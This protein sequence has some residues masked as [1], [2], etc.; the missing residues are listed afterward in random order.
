[1]EA[2]V[3]AVVFPS[4][5]VG[6]DLEISKEMS[7]GKLKLL[8]GSIESMPFPNNYFKF[9]HCYHVLEHVKRPQQA[10]MEFKRI[11]S[12]DGLIFIGFPIRLRIAPM[13]LKSHQSLNIAK[14]IK[15][16]LRDYRQKVSGKFKNE[17]G[18][19]AG[20]AESEFINIAREYFSTIKSFR[21]DYSKLIYPS[22]RILIDF[23]SILNADDYFFPSNYYLLRK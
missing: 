11:L 16:N 2:Q 14:K 4:N 3:L 9:V 8:K 15:Y 23:A 17:F 10:L 12:K 6:I 5:I 7:Q 21:K 1:M 13:Y 18:A 22:Y 20:F 19:H